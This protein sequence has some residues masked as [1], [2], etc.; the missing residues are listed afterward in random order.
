MT[1]A[2]TVCIA[3]TGCPAAKTETEG[4]VDA[5]SPAKVAPAP[6][7]TPPPEVLQHNIE[8]GKAQNAAAEAASKQFE[9][10]K[11]THPNGG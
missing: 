4:S 3:L 10:Y 8:S 5:T 7:A 11:K 2:A 1:A 6:I 9:E